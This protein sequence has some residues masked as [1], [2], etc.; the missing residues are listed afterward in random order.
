MCSFDRVRDAQADASDFESVRDD[1]ELSLGRLQ[2]KT[3][4]LKDDLK[5]AEAKEKA[6]KEAAKKSAQ[7]LSKK[8]SSSS[9]IVTMFMEE[10]EK[11]AKESAQLKFDISREQSGLVDETGVFDMQKKHVR[12]LE[13]Y[14]TDSIFRLMGLKA[15]V[16]VLSESLES[17]AGIDKLASSIG[18]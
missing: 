18:V 4:T 15:H 17:K 7:A 13:Q 2:R 12:Y 16:K 6:A 8:A 11:H 3:D 1:Q 14:R 9:E 5:K 10:Y